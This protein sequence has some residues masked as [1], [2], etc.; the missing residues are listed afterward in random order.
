MDDYSQ[1]L[2]IEIIAA[3]PDK[4][5]SSPGAHEENLDKLKTTYNS[6]MDIVSRALTLRM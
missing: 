6:C 4:L 5:N 2:L 3:I 1:K